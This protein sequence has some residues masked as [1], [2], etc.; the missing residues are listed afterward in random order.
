MLFKYKG[1]DKT[2]KKIKGTVT[3]SSPEEAGQKLRNSGI[4]HEG[5]TASKEFS[6]DAFSKRQMPTDLL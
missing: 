2:G 6:L 1:F 4:Y 5:L 3:A